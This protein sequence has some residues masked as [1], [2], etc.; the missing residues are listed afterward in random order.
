M[1]RIR[2]VIIAACGLSLIV[3]SAWLARAPLLTA[4]ARAWIIDDKPQKADAIVVLGGGVESR[5]FA[6]AQL[7]N[8]GFAPAVLIMDV[9]LSPTEELGIKDPERDVTRRILTRQG[10]PEAAIQSVGQSVHNT[11]EESLAVR[12]WAQ[13]NDAKRLLIT[14]EIFH[15][16]RVR[17]LFRKRFRG[18]GTEIRVVAAQPREY[19]A[20]NW[21]KNEQGLINFQNEWVKFPYYWAKY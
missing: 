8:E 7:Y 6:A 17:W 2:F 3:A 1:R 12:A 15:T 13:T 4:L 9:S 5:P 14:T 18:T 19:A 10:V 20:T 16:R 11:Y 21:W